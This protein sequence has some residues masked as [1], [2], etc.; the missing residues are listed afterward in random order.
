MISNVG[1]DEKDAEREEAWRGRMREGE[2]A[3]RREIPLL[4]LQALMVNAL[5]LS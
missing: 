1:L 4:V 5:F 3:A 2:E